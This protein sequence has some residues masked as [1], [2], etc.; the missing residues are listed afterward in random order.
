[1][2][3]PIIDMPSPNFDERKG[4]APSLLILH[5][6]GMETAQTALQRLTDPEAKVSSHYT[7]DEDGTV[8]R[9][10]DEGMR[11]WHAGHSYWKGEADI[12]AK[13]IGIEIVNPGHEWGY[14]P[15]TGHQMKALTVLCRDIIARNNIEPEDVL[16]HSDIA[17][18]RKEDPGEYFPWHEMAKHGIGVWPSPSDED[19][20]KAAGLRIEQALHDYGYD[21]RVKLRDKLTAFQRHFVPEAF[22]NGHAGEAD[23][24]TKTRL[25]ALLAG[26]FC[27]S[28]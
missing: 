8:Y 13:S 25:Y 28:Q 18:A 12:N 16:A 15:F 2:M 6:T 14:R 7:V 23:S 11:A 17:P 5:Y 9:H 24:L 22:V 26:H 4:E 10:V 21:P 3:N 19:A 1:M 20:V 27:Y